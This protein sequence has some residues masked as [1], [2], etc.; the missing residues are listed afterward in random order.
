[1]LLS[2]PCLKPVLLDHRR[3]MDAPKGLQIVEDKVRTMKAALGSRIGVQL[4]CTHPIVRWLVQHSADVI[5]KSAVNRSGLAPYEEL[6]GKK[7]KER[8][9]E[10][11]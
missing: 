10:F 4:P 1:M 11:G 8:R 3:Q 5:N 9:I 6:H 2:P 7:P